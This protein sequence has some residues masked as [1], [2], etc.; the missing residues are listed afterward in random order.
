MCAFSY[1]NFKTHFK[2]SVHN[3]VNTLL[4]WAYDVVC[5]RCL[6]SS[7]SLYGKDIQYHHSV[8][9]VSGWIL[10]AFYTFTPSKVTS[11]NKEHLH[12]SPLKEEK[13]SSSFIFVVGMVARGL[14]LF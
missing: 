5:S 13:C 7:N 1:L 14:T 3:L 10:Y 2:Y 6:Q 4:E 8:S 9:W 12:P 11:L